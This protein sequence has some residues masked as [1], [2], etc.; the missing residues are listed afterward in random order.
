VIYNKNRLGIF[1]SRGFHHGRGAKTKQTA[2]FTTL[3]GAS[4]SGMLRMARKYH[5]GV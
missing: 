5:P 3:S 2:I 4:D 1:K